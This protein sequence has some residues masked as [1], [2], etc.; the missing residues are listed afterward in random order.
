MIRSHLAA[1]ESEAIYVLRDGLAVCGYLW[2]QEGVIERD[3]GP[4]RIEGAFAQRAKARNRGL[5][6]GEGLALIG[7][8]FVARH[9]R[10]R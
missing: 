9:G 5:L 3:I 1:L 10:L 7:E 4:F 2:K 6:C 8:R